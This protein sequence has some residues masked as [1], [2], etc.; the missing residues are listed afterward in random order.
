MGAFD[1]D[2]D[3]I[4]LTFRLGIH[5]RETLNCSRSSCACLIAAASSGSQL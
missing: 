1:D 4:S 2:N 5:H 3:S